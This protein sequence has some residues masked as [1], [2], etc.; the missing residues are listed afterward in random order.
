MN[1]PATPPTISTDSLDHAAIGALIRRARTSKRI[2]L[3]DLAKALAVSAPYLSD[4]ERGRRN[5]TVER[6]AQAVKL[7]KKL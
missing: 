2:G 7:I 1:L 3:K 6:Y 4:L 5:W